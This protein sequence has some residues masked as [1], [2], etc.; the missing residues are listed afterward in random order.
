MNFHKIQYNAAYPAL[1]LYPPQRSRSASIHTKKQTENNEPVRPGQA[2]QSNEHDWLRERTHSIHNFWNCYIKSI[3]FVNY[4]MWTWMNL[5]NHFVLPFH[6]IP[7]G[8]LYH[9][10]NLKRWEV[11]T[12]KIILLNHILFGCPVQETILYFIECHC[13]QF[14]AIS[15]W[16]MVLLP[17]L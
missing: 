14:S 17:R 12:I 1:Y 9:I 13:A 3:Q 7:F 8:S 2:R 11:K 6:S 16:S 10:R 5:T 4:I 15:T